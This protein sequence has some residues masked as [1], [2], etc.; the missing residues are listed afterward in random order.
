MGLAGHV[1]RVGNKRGI[2]RVLVGTPE[3]E[4]Q[5][6]RPRHR[7]RIILKCILKKWVG[8]AWTGLLRLRTGTGG[9]CL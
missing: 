5:I 2:F 9:V 7:W 6:G 1:E 8:E 3:G 4:R